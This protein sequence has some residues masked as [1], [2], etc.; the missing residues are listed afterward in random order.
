M[1]GRD[2][3]GASGIMGP[4]APEEIPLVALDRYCIKMRAV[5]ALDPKQWVGQLD[6]SPNT[7]HQTQRFYLV[8]PHA[9]WQ[10]SLPKNLWL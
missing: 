10:Q 5:P 2:T 7:L 1:D 3:A 6:T 9:G 4:D 8:I